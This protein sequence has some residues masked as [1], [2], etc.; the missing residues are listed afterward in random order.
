MVP[1]VESLKSQ[2]FW[3][4]LLLCIHFREMKITIKTEPMRDSLFFNPNSLTQQK[5][6]VCFFA[7][8]NETDNKKNRILRW[9]ATQLRSWPEALHKTF[10][11]QNTPYHVKILHWHSDVSSCDAD[12]DARSHTRAH[13]HT[14]KGS[15]STFR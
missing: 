11:R 5:G 9:K 3:Y 12:M 6:M 7:E 2:Y 10:F 8:Q 14:Q 4:W 1:Y 15:L 13:T